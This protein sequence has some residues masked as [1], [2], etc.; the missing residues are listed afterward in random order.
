MYFRIFMTIIFFGP[1]YSQN[2]GLLHFRRDESS[3][4]VC[5]REYFN[6]VRYYEFGRTKAAIANFIAQGISGRTVSI[7]Y[8]NSELP[9]LMDFFSNEGFI[10]LEN[11]NLRTQLEIAIKEAILSCSDIDNSAKTSLPHFIDEPVETHFW[12][13]S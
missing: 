1:V 2:Y 4:S 11:V 7:D 12:T 5:I 9:L 13:T 6:T 3:L 8:L 10:R